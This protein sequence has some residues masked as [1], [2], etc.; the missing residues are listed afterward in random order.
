MNH[1]TRQDFIQLKNMLCLY[2]NRYAG[3]STEAMH[4]QEVNGA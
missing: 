2:S 3:T 4:I 1:L